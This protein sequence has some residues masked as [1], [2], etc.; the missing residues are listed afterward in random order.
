[1][2]SKRADVRE[3]IEAYRRLCAREGADLVL[4]ASRKALR[5]RHYLLVARVAEHAGERLLY[6]LESDLIAAHGRFLVDP[7]KR[8]P[9]CVAKGAIARAL[10]CLDC[11]D[12]DFYIA[13]IHY[14]QPEPV[15][16]G[17]M[18]TA[19]DMRCSCG[20]GLAGTSYPRALIE[21]VGLLHDPEAH[22]RAAAV[23]AIAC[24]D[25]LGAE[26]VLRAKALTGDP[27]PEVIG[28][29][30]TGLLRLAPE[31]SVDFVAG[32]LD[33]PEPVTRELAAL[34][35]GESRLDTA[36]EMLRARWDE[37]PLKRDADRLL[38]R[39]AVLH[40]GDAALDWLVSVAA[41]GDSKS[42][43]QVILELAAY[44]HNTRLRGRLQEALAERGDQRLWLHFRNAWGSD[45]D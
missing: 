23:R 10:V 9:N 12:A 36:L 17:T 5:D 35:L 43:E 40:R 24:V 11:Q 13:G 7:V 28:E 15:W 25:P 31:E 2:G 39:A 30:L 29:C 8:D 42:A 18:D 27:E 21:L 34:A 3:R 45:A 16:G 6:D 32:L 22:A 20:E 33:D 44:R 14:L 4:D 1:M 41:D 37:Q 26:A 19:V 38:L